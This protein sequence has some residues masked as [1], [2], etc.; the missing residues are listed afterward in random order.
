M[1]QLLEVWKVGS[2]FAFLVGV[3]GLLGITETVGRKS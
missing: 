3:S 2:C 1:K